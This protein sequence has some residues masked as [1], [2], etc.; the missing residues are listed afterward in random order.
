L[1]ISTTSL[2]LV[3]YIFP[4][5]FVKHLSIINLR[6][7]IFYKISDHTNIK[8]SCD[9]Y[10]FYHKGNM[11]GIN[12][13]FIS[14]FLPAI[15]VI[16]LIGCA[17]FTP[18]VPNYLGTDQVVNKDY[19]LGVKKTTYVGE[20]MI[21]VKDYYLSKYSAKTISPNVD[22]TT[23]YGRATHTFYALNEYE[24]VGTTVKD[25]INFYLLDILPT[26]PRSLLLLIAQNGEVD[27][28]FL[29]PDDLTGGYQYGWG[30]YKLDS[31]DAK[32]IMQDITK[33]D[34][35]QGYENYEL[36]YTGKN[37]DTLHITYREYS[38]EDL[39][40]TAFFQ[41]LTYPADAKVIRFKGFKIMVD[42]ATSESITFK[43][44]EE[45]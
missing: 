7:N 3:Y 45:G 39:A 25:G 2:Q 13:I 11:R 37:K 19:E 22:L 33:T 35:T 14:Y 38:P 5:D 44:I 8:P 30:R 36:I 26:H 32:F 21:K 20:S 9:G 29:M 10:V 31:P 41:N 27:G 23:K 40:R 18:Y 28:R 4:L 17:S 1:L 43:V 16:C 6:S 34:T 15:S 12:K 24:I 42:E